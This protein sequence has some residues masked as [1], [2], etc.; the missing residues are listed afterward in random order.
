MLRLCGISFIGCSDYAQVET[1]VT[2]LSKTLC[3]LDLP[4]DFCSFVQTLVQ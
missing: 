1:S 3:G 4:H 2:C